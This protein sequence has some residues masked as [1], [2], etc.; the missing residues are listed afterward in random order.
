MFTITVPTSLRHHV[1]LHAVLGHE[2]GHAA[3]NLAN[4]GEFM[5]GL[6]KALTGGSMVGDT[7]KLLSWNLTGFPELPYVVKVPQLLN[8][9]VKN[10]MT[11]VACDIFG[12]ALMGPSF[13]GAMRTL[14]DGSDP[15]GIAYG[16]KHPSHAWRFAALARA[17]RA[18]EWEKVPDGASASLKAAIESFNA[19]TLKYDGA[20]AHADEVFAPDVIEKAAL[21]VRDFLNKD[22]LNAAYTVPEV[23]PL[24]QLYGTLMRLRPPVG[25][26]FKSK[27]G[28]FLPGIDYRHVLHVGW[29]AQHGKPE[30]YL[31]QYFNFFTINR[32]CEQAIIQLEAV[33]IP[34]VNDVSP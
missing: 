26:D 28:A 20:A 33:R 5:T 27:D 7:T 32:L 29:L 12:L 11:E 24:E 14:F 19:T 16:A 10:W 18:L 2:L 17:Y 9:L 8:N 23:A 34:P 22:G 6:I 3:S 30:D 13:A 4:Q 15:Q 21:S 1:L 31:K 25:Q